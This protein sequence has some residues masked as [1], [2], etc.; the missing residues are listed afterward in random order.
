VADLDD[1]KAL[2]QRLFG[3]ANK[4]AD[5]PRMDGYLE[6][7]RLM[8]TPRLLRVVDKILA[9][10]AE[11]TEP[12]NYKPPTAGQIWK[13]AR[14]MRRLPDPRPLELTPPPAAAM[15]GWEQNANLLLMQYLWAA[16]AGKGV[17][18]YAPDSPNPAR[19][20]PQTI[21]RTAI[22]VKFKNAWARDMR[23]DR[24]EGGKLDGKTHW[25]DCMALAEAE[26]DRYI[27]SQAQEA[28]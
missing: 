22:L 13:V 18:R 16:H 26:L 12:E 5:E 25:I 27:G 28:A 24:E 2:I 8:D 6:S 9:G 11:L 14:S 15:D 21:E 20:G 7:L 1:R 4:H 23:E 10:I 19:P 17:T 3:A